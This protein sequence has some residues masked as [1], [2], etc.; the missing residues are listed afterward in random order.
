[1]SR[2][3]LDDIGA[4]QAILILGR[5]GNLQAFHVRGRLNV[6]SMS[7]RGDVAIPIRISDC[8]LD[9]YYSP[10]VFY[11]APVEWISCTFKR[12]EIGAGAYFTKGLVCRDTEFLSEILYDSGG[13]NSANTPILFGRVKFHKFVDF[14]DCWFK[15]PVILRNVEFLEGTNLLDGEHGWVTFEVPPVLEGVRGPVD[16]PQNLEFKD[17]AWALTEWSPKWGLRRRGAQDVSKS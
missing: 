14:F 6:L 2:L 16:L 10:D 13:H 15:G 1:M 17:G 5:Q 3:E 11:E 9:E 7:D 8:V 12:I 4:E